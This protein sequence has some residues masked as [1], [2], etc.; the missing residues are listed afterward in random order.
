MKRALFTLNINDYCPAIREITYPLFK[1]YAGKI[2]AEFIEITGRKFPEWPVVYEKLQI[3]Q[4]GRKYDWSIFFDADAM[5]HP[6][7]IDFT[8][9]LPA[10]SVLHNAVDMAAVRFR[11][12]EFF[13]KDGRNLGTTGWFSASHK[14][15][16]DFWRPT[17]QTVQEVLDCCRLTV[18]ERNSGLMDDGHLVD[19]YVKSRNLARYGFPHTIVKELLPKVGLGEAEFFWHSYN[20]TDAEKIQKMQETVRR[21]QVPK[22]IMNG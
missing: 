15:A 9:L 14:D 7:C 1:Y 6:E 13:A 5:V 4:L 19:D 17:D 8:W 3:H 12:D 21:W 11:Y 22:E 20:I 10:G 16:I 18:G 2:G